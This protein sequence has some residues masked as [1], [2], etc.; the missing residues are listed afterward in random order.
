MGNCMYCGEKS[1]DHRHYAGCKELVGKTE[2]HSRTDTEPNG[3]IGN[4]ENSRAGVRR[5]QVENKVLGFIAEGIQE[6]IISLDHKLDYLGIDSLDRSTVAVEMEESY[7]IKISEE[8]VAEWV[9]VKDVVNTVC[10]LREK[11][12][13][14]KA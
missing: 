6:A 4:I 10:G 12:L 2:G 9:T 11:R 1:A 14:I 5:S 13:K 3:G 8:I 7:K